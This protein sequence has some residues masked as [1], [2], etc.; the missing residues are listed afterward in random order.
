MVKDKKDKEIFFV[1][2]PFHLINSTIIALSKAND[3]CSILIFIDQPENNENPYGSI[4][5]NWKNSPFEKIY[6]FES[7]EGNSIKKYNFRKRILNEISELVN[8]IRPDTI[9]TG[10][11]RRIEFIRAYKESIKLNPDCRCH[12][13]DDGLHSYVLFKYAWENPLEILI[14]RI[15]Y[16][17]WYQRHQVVGGS[18]FLD[19][20]YLSFPDYSHQLLDNKKKHQIDFSLLK[21]KEYKRFNKIVLDFFNLKISYIKQLDIILILPHH[22]ELKIFSSI[23]KQLKELIVELASK[24]YVVGI[25]YHPFHKTDDFN[26]RMVSKIKIIPPD[27]A[28]E[29]LIPYIKQKAS[30]IGDVS[31]V[32]LTSKLINKDLK[33]FSLVNSSDSRQN[34]L[35][36]LSKSLGI[37]K[38]ETNEEI[39][40]LIS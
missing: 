24:N 22:K 3:T 2:T 28:F 35:H 8:D 17:F 39:K 29:F 37:K 38:F 1:S 33:V 9:Y 26:F 7:K 21:R 25:K 20:A 14:K 6:K 13:V 11:D 30:I 12:Y 4:I 16:G 15:F 32:L 40:L 31:T 5:S 10:N 23:Y 18:T 36:R 34:S 19:K 27:I